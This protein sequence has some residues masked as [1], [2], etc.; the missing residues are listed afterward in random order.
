MPDHQRN[1]E[2]IQLQAPAMLEDFRTGFYY[3]GIIYNY[4]T[5]GV[6]LES[7]YAP[8]PG[9]KAYLRVDGWSDIF[10]R[11]VY[12]AEIKWRRSLP[13]N[14]SIYSFGVGVMFC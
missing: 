10:T 5:E 11:Q 6:Y 3:K 1:S 8:R 14:S 7:E 9:R 12:V 13:E 2:R 4:S